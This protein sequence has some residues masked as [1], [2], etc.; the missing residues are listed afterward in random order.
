M[1]IFKG[2]RTV[3]LN[4]AILIAAVAATLTG[5]ITDPDILKIVIIVQSVANV[6]LR[7]LTDTKVGSST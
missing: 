7:V 3:V 1:D 6:V 4:A 5:Q 2:W